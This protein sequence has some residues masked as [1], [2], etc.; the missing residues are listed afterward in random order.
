MPQLYKHA[1]SFKDL[2]IARYSPPSLGRACAPCSLKD[3]QLDINL[4]FVLPGKY[5]LQRSISSRI[6]PKY[7]KTNCLSL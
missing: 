1:T 7:P 6:P 4:Y 5:I 2:V 3:F